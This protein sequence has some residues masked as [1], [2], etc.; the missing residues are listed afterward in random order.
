MSDRLL[1][2]QMRNI[3]VKPNETVSLDFLFEGK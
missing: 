1:G 2:M 3:T